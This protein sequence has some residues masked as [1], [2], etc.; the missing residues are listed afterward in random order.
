MFWAFFRHFQRAGT[1]ILAGAALGNE[2][3]QS[4]QFVLVCPENPAVLYRR[5]SAVHPAAAGPFLQFVATG[6]QLF[7][8]IGQPPFVLIEQ[9]VMRAFVRDD[10]STS[11][12]VNYHRCLDL[13]STCRRVESLRVQSLGNLG[14]GV[15]ARTQL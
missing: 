12:E 8:K 1:T 9:F 5:F 6:L 11:Q 10:A 3:A 4:P 7:G 13:P 14:Y 15:P 2:S